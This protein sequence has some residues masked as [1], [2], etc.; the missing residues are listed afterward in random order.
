MQRRIIKRVLSL[1][2]S[3]SIAATNAIIMPAD[4]FAQE[5]LSN[6]DPKS[7]S[8]SVLPVVSNVTGSDEASAKIAALNSIL[9]A[10]GM[11]N[12]YF[13]KLDIDASVFPKSFD[14]REI[15]AV[16]SVKNQGNYGTC[17]TFGTMASIESSLIRKN[18]WVDLSEWQVAYFTFVGDDA[19]YPSASELG[20]GIYDQGGWTLSFVNTL[21]QWIGPTSE[22]NIPY[23]SGDPDDSQ[24]YL[25]DYHLRDALCLNN[26]YDNSYTYPETDEIKHLIYSSQSAAAISFY[27]DMEF[28]NFDTNASCCLSVN[29]SNHIVSV[30]GWDD[31]YSRFNFNSNSRPRKNG[32]WLCKNSWGVSEFG[33]NGYFWISYE[34]TSICE[35]TVISVDSAE[36]Y[37]NLYAYDTLMWGASVA[38]DPLE[39]YSSYMANIFTAN[40]DE[41]IT[42]AAFYTTDNNAQYEITVYTQISDESDPTSGN[43]SSVTSGTVQFAGYHTVDLNECVAINAGEKYSI[44]VKLT[45]PSIP[46]PIPVEASFVYAD[47]YMTLYSYYSTYEKILENTQPGQSFISLEGDDW[48][49]TCLMYYDLTPDID[50]STAQDNL[51]KA[52][53][54]FAASGSDVT[55]I[56]DIIAENPAEEYYTILGNV[57][58]KAITNNRQKVSFS[59]PSG[60]IFI[61]EEIEL[62]AVDCD[63]IYYTLD[64]SDPS[65][66]NGILYTEPILLPEGGTINAVCLKDGI[67]GDI[68]TA[69]YQTDIVALSSLVVN[70]G[71]DIYELSFDELAEGFYE[72]CYF[73]ID[74]YSDTVSFTMISAYDTTINGQPVISGRAT[75][76]PV[77]YGENNF[78]IIVSDEK[79][80]SNEYSISVYREDIKFDTIT[81]EIIFIEDSYIITAPDGTEIESGF[82]FTEFVGKDF[83]VYDILNDE[84]IILTAPDKALFDLDEAFI[85]YKESI[86]VNFITYDMLMSDETEPL[87][88]IAYDEEM[89]D[90]QSVAEGLQF[91]DDS[92]LE[93]I[94]D[95]LIKWSYGE[96]DQEMIDEFTDYIIPRIGI[97]VSPGETIY[98]Q[99]PASEVALASDV[100]S[101][102]V[103][104]APVL[105]QDN[106]VISEV[107][108]NSI[109]LE[110][111][112][113]CEYAIVEA[114]AYDEIYMDYDENIYFSA[115]LKGIANGKYNSKEIDHIYDDLEIHQ[116]E[117]DWQDSPVFIDLHSGTDYIVAIRKK[118]TENSF[119]S[120]I[121]TEQQTTTGT[122]PLVKIDFADETIIFDIEKCTVSTPAGTKIAPYSI[123]SGYIGKTLIVTPADSS[124]PA[125]EFIIPARPQSLEVS[126]NYD[127]RIS[128]AI[129]P[130][131]TRLSYSESIFDFGEESVSTF[132]D[133]PA[134]FFTNEEGYLDFNNINGLVV[135]F[136]TPANKKNFASDKFTLQI[137][138]ILETYEIYGEVEKLTSDSVTFLCYDVN[139][140]YSIMDNETGEMS[141]WQSSPQFIGLEA[142]TDYVFAIQS[143]ATE[144]SFATDPLY[145]VITTRIQDFACYNYSLDECYA[146]LDNFLSVLENAQDV[147]CVSVV[148]DDETIAIITDEDGIVDVTHFGLDPEIAYAYID[149]NGAV[150][151]IPADFSFETLGRI[152]LTLKDYGFNQVYVFDAIDPENGLIY[153][154]PTYMVGD[155]NLDGDINIRDLSLLIKHYAELIELKG[156]SLK[157]ADCNGDGILSLADLNRLAKYIVGFDVTLGE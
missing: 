129:I 41:D 30:V 36:K 140:L 95:F 152:I 9:G 148:C 157:A 22:S 7:A 55:D 58:L 38:A 102:V 11:G 135:D 106:L 1:L 112:D 20:I 110:P 150:V 123:I 63:E 85:N 64:G 133:L 130:E 122:S 37:D 46:Y 100:V 18:P 49:D 14:L 151:F 80:G 153:E 21:A 104:D 27:V 61:D 90:A 74:F 105:E 16:S 113:G 23:D 156:D 119:A 73:Y 117:Y 10:S 141:E 149:E 33:D 52:K 35:A 132:I 26:L 42:A 76:I 146:M 131:G 142:G 87:L 108:D 19:I 89:T 65:L 98:F 34:D 134:S 50:Y 116:D 125:Y 137:P 139:A 91:T 59:V 8:I 97:F 70:A 94:L 5:S 62:S 13:D 86:L 47:E 40:G 17:W 77:E 101:Y 84:T 143:G 68:S 44:V 43:A 75:E 51:E 128:N 118:S 114:N 57:C 109:A 136:Y 25:A 48:S 99:V 66:E 32:A 96:V 28:Y 127:E 72:D 67:Y 92:D 53:S 78:T 93:Y 120:Q 111:V 103:P 147:A 126:I 3:A 2:T 56:F 4:T 79:A 83:I 45:N 39:S 154:F 145:T 144:Y 69:Y 115:L 82:D 88:Y 6:D 138:P 31:N 107:T 71:N 29:H 15:G 54:S 124:E 24:R 60:G 12:D 155:I 121:I 81:K